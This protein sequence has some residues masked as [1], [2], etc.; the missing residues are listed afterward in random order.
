LSRIVLADLLGLSASGVTRLLNPMEKLGLIERQVND[1]DARLSLVKLTNVGMLKFEDSSISAGEA[2][3]DI[4]INVT[5]DEKESL[6]SI[7]SRIN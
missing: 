2:I 6:L 1:R 7:I 4:F 3:A 5:Q